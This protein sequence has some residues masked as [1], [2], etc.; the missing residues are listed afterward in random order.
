MPFK[1]FEKSDVFKN[2]IKTTPYFEF[3]IYGGKTYLNNSQSGYTQ[4]NVINEPVV[5][6]PV[7]GCPNPNSFD[8]SCEENSQ[9]ISL[10]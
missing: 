7:V 9:N 8:F 2:V 10:I 6:A 3:K 5:L 1:K 4:L